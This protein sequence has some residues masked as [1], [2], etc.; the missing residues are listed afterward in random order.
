MRHHVADAPFGGPPG[1]EVGFGTKTTNP[2]LGACR[3]L[4]VLFQRVG[5]PK[6]RASVARRVEEAY[7]MVRPGL[8]GLL[9]DR[10]AYWSFGAVTPVS[11]ML[12]APSFLASG[13]SHPRHAIGGSKSGCD[14]M[15]LI[16]LAVVL[17]ATMLYYYTFLFI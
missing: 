17:S 12:R 10:R 6:V 3:K 15:C 2:G 14:V 8:Y 9:G 7:A 4:V 11:I 1:A 16:G 5:F 13:C